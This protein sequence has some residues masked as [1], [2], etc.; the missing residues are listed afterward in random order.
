MSFP[1]K[2]R[3]RLFIGDWKGKGL[4]NEELGIKYSMTPGGVK[5]LKQRLRVKDRSL[6]EKTPT[7]KP[8]TQQPGKKRPPEG[9][10]RIEREGIKEVEGAFGGAVKFEP[11]RE[12]AKQQASKLAEYKKVTY[13]LDPAM[14]KDIKRLALERDKDISELVREILGKYLKNK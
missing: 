9:L 10:T 6:Y 11:T 13:Y 2:E 1:K 12:P 5:A 3:N 8:A 7:S 14:A 4:T